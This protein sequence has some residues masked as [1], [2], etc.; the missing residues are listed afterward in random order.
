MSPSALGGVSLPH[1]SQGLFPCCCHHS[2]SQ[3]PKGFRMTVAKEQ[4]PTTLHGLFWRILRQFGVG[5]AIAT[6][7]IVC[8]AYVGTVAIDKAIVPLIDV[9]KENLTSQTTQ[10]RLQT[11]AMGTIAAEAARTGEFRLA[12]AEIHKQQLLILDQIREGQ[13]RLEEQ[14]KQLMDQNRTLIQEL[15]AMCEAMR[16]MFPQPNGAKPNGNGNGPPQGTVPGK[17]RITP[18]D[19]GWPG[20]GS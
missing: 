6:G 18:A 5:A 20:Y 1:A 7:M 15:R 10:L 8:F 16:G 13:I 17:S 2:L 11:Q 19:S 9:V 4:D 3:S 14:N 12:T